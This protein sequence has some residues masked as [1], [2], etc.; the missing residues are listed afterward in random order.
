MKKF[1]LLDFE[2]EDIFQNDITINDLIG[3]NNFFLKNEYFFPIK[4]YLGSPKY[5]WNPLNK[6]I[7]LGFRNLATILNPTYYLLFLRRAFLFVL[8]S[9]KN[10]A[11]SFTIFTLNQFN[12]IKNLIKSLKQF[13][14]GIYYPGFLSNAINVI[15]N[16]R[17]IEGKKNQFV[18]DL[19]N[20]PDYCFCFEYS[21]NYGF[22]YNE[23][24][25]LKMPFI[26][27]NNSDIAVPF[28]MYGI[29]SNNTGFSSSLYFTIFFYSIIKNGLN[30]KKFYFLTKKFK[31]FFKSTKLF[32]FKFKKTF[33]TLKFNLTSN[34][35][36]TNL[37][38]QNYFNLEKNQNQNFYYKLFYI[39]KKN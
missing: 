19:K 9:S 39:L 7:L 33:E 15:A 31:L 14:T 27:L 16:I 6:S 8:Y 17:G 12:H 11:K 10:F 25:S 18:F 2:F 35:Y 22:L 29:I 30:I 36:N 1:L 23:C 13:A 3:K 26:S 28:S 32:H 34:F 21:K 20:F 37:V 24:I 5:N 4:N 38:N